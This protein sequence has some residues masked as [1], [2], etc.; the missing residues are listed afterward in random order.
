MSKLVSL[1]FSYLIILSGTT[2]PLFASEEDFAIWRN[3]QLEVEATSF[4]KVLLDVGVSNGMEGPV[5]SSMSLSIEGRK[6]EVPPAELSKLIRADLS[7]L[8]VTSE[9]G[10]P[11]K[12]LGPFLYVKLRGMSS[13]PGEFVFR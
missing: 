6:F 9:V 1:I 11:Q 7:S 4:G 12:G 5:L 8:K 10:Y 2:T 13:S 3:L